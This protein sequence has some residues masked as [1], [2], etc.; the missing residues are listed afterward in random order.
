MYILVLRLIFNVA[1]WCMLKI[2]MSIDVPALQSIFWFRSSFDEQHGVDYGFCQPSAGAHAAKHANDVRREICLSIGAQ[3]LI[4]CLPRFILMGMVWYSVALDSI[5]NIHFTD[6]CLFK[7]NFDACRAF[8]G[9]FIASVVRS[10]AHS[11][12]FP[13]P[14]NLKLVVVPVFISENSLLLVTS[15]RIVNE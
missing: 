1:V 4:E 6:L 5:F 15:R 13:F 7:P 3:S 9:S 12:P 14:G 8:D 11:I 10:L 2:E